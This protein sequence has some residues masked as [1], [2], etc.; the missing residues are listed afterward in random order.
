MLYS[1]LASGDERGNTEINKLPAKITVYL[2]D[3]ERSTQGEQ[4]A[5]CYQFQCCAPVKTVG[6]A[7]T[8]TLITLVISVFSWRLGSSLIRGNQVTW[9]CQRLTDSLP[10]RQMSHLLLSG[11][12]QFGLQFKHGKAEALMCVFNTLMQGFGMMNEF[13]WIAATCVLHPLSHSVSL[14]FLSFPTKKRTH[15]LPHSLTIPVT[16][17]TGS[18]KQQPRFAM[19]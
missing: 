15:T 10:E 13:V 5:G 8:V 16:I 4:P 3:Q 19:F 1:A 6:F 14:A 9:V 2:I 11:E 17:R 18:V 7:L 12:Q